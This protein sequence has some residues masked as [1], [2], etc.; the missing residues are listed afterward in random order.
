[1]SNEI[2]I[3]DANFDQEVVQSAVP[4]LVDFWAPWCGPCRMIG[5]VIEELA[6]EYAGKVKVGK[7]NTDENPETASKYQISAIPTILF[8]KGGKM[9]KDAVGLQPKEEL[10]KI[11]D[12]LI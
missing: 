7:L 9:V 11:M 4:V 1:M 3:T 10:K 6:K 5:P 12:S 8:F 2:Q